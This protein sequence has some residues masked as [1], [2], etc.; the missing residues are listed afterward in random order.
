M[1]ITK[2]KLVRHINETKKIGVLELMS[3]DKLTL[4]EIPE[5]INGFT[6]G[7][8]SI[9]RTPDGD[10]TIK[11]EEE[12]GAWR[13]RGEGGGG[14]AELPEVTSDDNGKVLG[15]VDGAWDKMEMPKI[16]KHTIDQFDCSNQSKITLTFEGERNI[17]PLY[18]HLVGTYMDT[19]IDY[20]PRIYA[21]LTYV[22]DNETYVVFKAEG[23]PDDGTTNSRSLEFYYYE[24]PTE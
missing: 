11:G 23:I 19:F 14:E 2:I 24:L 21:P 13:K 22:Y 18:C 7:T 9:L 4:S 17:I 16:Q 15:V 5:T 10:F 1:K 6:I 8:G 20:E 12:W 3:D